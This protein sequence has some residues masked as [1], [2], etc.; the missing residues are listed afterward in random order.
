M[1]KYVILS[2]PL[3]GAL[4]FGYIGVYGAFEYKS[5]R[6]LE[7]RNRQ[8]K[9]QINMVSAIDDN[10]KAVEIYKTIMP[11]A[12]D[13][14]LSILQRQWLISLEM[15][16]RIR[17]ARYNDVLEDEV[18]VFY[19]QLLVH[20]DDMHNRCSYV[21]TEFEPLECDIAWRVYNIKGAVNLL[22]A[23]V[24]LETEKIWKKVRGTMKEAISDLKS[25]V[26]LVDRTDSP[27]FEKNIPRWN[28]ELL[29]ANQ[30]IRKVGF[31]KMEAER[32]LDLRENLE[33][34][35]PE[36][37]GYAPGEPIERRMKK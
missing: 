15:V 20:L 11:V 37:G 36:K 29:Q 9:V 5:H 17:L 8:M 32:R 7:T 30:Y 21:L 4:I 1:K 2:L 6:S 3:L 22:R 16:D 34:I 25:S 12:P 23:F 27:A 10:N 14:Q 18:P 33:A 26:E 24:V 31:S 19:K 13:V 28:L 35:I